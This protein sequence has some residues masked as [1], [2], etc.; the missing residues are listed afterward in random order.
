MRN[1]KTFLKEASGKVPTLSISVV[2]N[3]NPDRDEQEDIAQAAEK[4]EYVHSIEWNKDNMMTTYFNEMPAYTSNK[5]RLIAFCEDYVSAVDDILS[6][7][8]RNDHLY[9]IMDV[10]SILEYKGLPSSFIEF[11]YIV[12][13]CQPGQVLTGLHKLVKCDILDLTACEN[14][15]GHVL[16]LMQINQKTDIDLRGKK[17]DPEWCLIVRDHLEERDLLDCKEELMNNGLK[18]YA[19]I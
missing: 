3:F 8:K 1:F 11:P 18:E 14:V 12:I 6:V 5:S 2:I 7:Y 15:V 19:K 16:S 13:E 4:E 17:L 10:Q 9:R